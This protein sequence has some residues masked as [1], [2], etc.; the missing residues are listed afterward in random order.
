LEQCDTRVVPC[1][2]AAAFR[3]HGDAA[4][5]AREYIPSLRSWSESTFLA[6]LAPDRPL[7][8]RQGI[9]EHYYGAYETLVRESPR[10][11]GKDN[12]HLYMT[13]AKPAAE[14]GAGAPAADYG[15]APQE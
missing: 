10:G 2:F 6:A 9:I 12:V 13:L 14:D 15:S 11:H 8:E 5:F 1:P 4:R 7:E 3:Q